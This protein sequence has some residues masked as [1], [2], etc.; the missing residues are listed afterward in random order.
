MKQ[1]LFGAAAVVALI[2][3]GA[4]CSEQKQSEFNFDSVTQEVTISAKITYDAGVEID[5]MNPSGYKIANAKPAVGRKVFVEIP[6]A[7]YSGGAAAGNKI[8]ETVTDENGVFTITVPTKSTGINGSIRL[9]EFTALYHEYVKMENGKPVFKTKMYSYDTP[10]GLNNINLKP[11]QFKFPDNNDIEYVKHAL[12]VPEFEENVTI[13]G[14]INLAYETGF[15]QGAFKSANNANVEFEIAYPAVAGM[16][17]LK[18]GTT[19]DANGNYKITIPMR[20]LS[21]GFTI[22]AIQ[23]L[24]IGDNAFKHWVSDTIEEPEIIKGAYTLAG[25]AGGAAGAIAFGN[26]IDGITYD[27]GAKNLIFTPYYNANITNIPAPENWTTD[28]IGWSAGR[29]DLG[30]DET[31]NKSVKLTGKIYM[32]YLKEYGVGAYKNERQTIKISSAWVDPASGEQPYNN[33]LIIITEEDGTF[34]VDL[35]V[36][37]DDDLRPFTVELEKDM[38]PFEFKGS[39][40]NTPLYD[41]TYGNVIHIQEEGVEWYELGDYFF[42]FSPDAG[43]TPDEW[44]PNL[45]GWYRNP[46]FKKIN[47]DKKIKGQFLYA[48]ETAYGK[49]K[50]EA[51]PFIVTIK[52]AQAGE[53][54]RYFAVKPDANGYIEFDL[55]LKDELDQPV[56]SVNDANFPTKEYVHY[57]EYGKNNTRLIEDIYTEYKKVYDKKDPEWN[58]KIGTRYYK[59]AVATDV[60]DLPKSF[61]KNLADW[62]RCT[63]AN[64]MMYEASYQVSGSAKFAYETGFLKGDWKA[65]EGQIINLMI[66]AADPV[67]VLT[68][69]TGAFKFDIPIKKVGFERD[70]QVNA[71]ENIKFDK[72]T[73]YKNATD[74]QIISGEYSGDPVSED[75]AKWYQLGTVYYTFTPSAGEVKPAGFWNKYCKYIAGWMPAKNGYKFENKAAVTGTVKVISEKSARNGNYVAF[76]YLPVLIQD[77]AGNKYVGATDKD[78]KFSIDVLRK[79][80]DD[81]PTITFDAASTFSSD[82]YGKFT[83][84]RKVGNNATEKLEGEYAYKGKQDDPSDKWN[85]LGIKYY[86]FNNTTLGVTDWNTDLP[87]WN[88]YK[89][90]EQTEITIYAKVMRAVEKWFDPAKGVWEDEGNNTATVTVDGT[91]YPVAIKSGEI[92]F[93]LMKK[94]APAKVTLTIVPDDYKVASFDHWTNKNKETSLDPVKNYKYTSANNIAAENCNKEEGNI[95][96][97]AKAA[98][99]ILYI[100][101]GEGYDAPEGWTQYTWNPANDNKD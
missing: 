51:K 6:F 78:G 89:A 29:G 15:R 20:S 101:A 30:F 17:P 74:T 28:L 24:G 16:A 13:A 70:V 73:H 9:E 26:V 54:D 90:D 83:H 47:P 4:S 8:F 48:V 79:Y 32:P 91:D 23:V 84:Y 87:G 49:G 100:N 86:T 5:S 41:G 81:E 31:Y 40:K 76:Q 80:A 58:E 75:D 88:I 39:K 50:Y 44:N 60:D 94:E 46:V 98:K 3:A 53:A 22:N 96:K 21:E 52:A 1:K 33:G 77:E 7:Q 27:L 14:S 65:A 68:D 18:F 38:Q 63:D 92:E 12:D 10:A 66:D 35:P 19:T 71:G 59:F 99:M 37:G 2:L 25:I 69:N 72:F 45:I 67:Q 62:Y 34:S 82:D 11:G 56:L 61:H 85:K 57:T 95:Y 97:P 42:K 93:T 64:D 36:N 55:P 43:N